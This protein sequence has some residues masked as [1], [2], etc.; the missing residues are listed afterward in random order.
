[1]AWDTADIEIVRILQNEGRITNA[2]LAQ[3]IGLTPGPTLARVHKLESAGILKKYVGLVDREK[4]GLPF[5]A[6]VS[7]IMRAHTK[8]AAHAF[9]SAVEGLP[10]VLECHHIAGAEDYLLKVVAA[11]PADY[12]TFV[13]EKLMEIPDI[14]RVHTTIVLSSP[15]CET[16]VQVRGL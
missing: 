3:R 8:D 5:T 14:Q 2:E 4:A 1:M 9:L 7:V 16:A 15:K 6:F 10:E 13:L 11:S 12:E